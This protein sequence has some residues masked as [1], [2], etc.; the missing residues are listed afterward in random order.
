MEKF[1]EISDYSRPPFLHSY[2]LLQANYVSWNIM[3][4]GI[5]QTFS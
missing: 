2:L 4:R 1:I 3:F 5:S